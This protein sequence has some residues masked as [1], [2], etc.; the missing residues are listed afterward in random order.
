MYAEGTSKQ[1]IVVVTGITTWDGQLS[2]GVN[3]NGTQINYG[4]PYMIQDTSSGGFC[5]GAFASSALGRANLVD[6]KHYR[7]IM[8]F[9]GSGAA[10]TLH[11]YLHDLDSDA[12][13]EM[14]SMTT[15][16]FFT[17][18]DAAVG[19][20]TLE[21]LVGSIVLYGKFGV[22]CTI[23]KLHGV[24]ENA[25]LEEVAKALLD[26]E[27]GDSGNEPETTLDMLGYDKYTDQFD[28]YAYSSYSDGTYEIDGQTYYIGKN[29][30]NLKQYSLYGEAG[31]T[32]Y[33]PQNDCVVDGTA[34]SIA[35]AK[36]LIDDLA[37]VGIKKTILQDSRILYMSMREGALPAEYDTDEEMD[38]YIY[39]CIKDYADYEGVY[40][41]Q[42]GDEPKYSMLTAYAAVYKSL[43][44]VSDKYGY[45][46]H[47][48][49]NLNP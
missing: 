4:H 43:K 8:G 1:G 14:S 22:D 3:G 26:T 27:G 28:F 31:L 21:D 42:L 30:A 29:L 37:E 6:G 18:S 10:I 33:F 16:N 19:N 35:K 11:W 12:L 40:G 15:W 41:I 34:E 7:V 13:V 25:T 24:Y 2:S 44:R 46:L 48:Q 32:I 36:A 47:I 39:N 49:Y 38:A 5:Q 20:M 17:G 23:D 9:S 45:D